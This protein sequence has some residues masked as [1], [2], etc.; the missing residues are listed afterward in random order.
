M[1][2]IRP[3]LPTH[4]AASTALRSYLADVA[5]R[6]YGRPATADEVDAALRD[7]PSDE[8]APPT[9]A[10]WLAELDGRVVGCIGV[11]RVR[12]EQVRV[13]HVPDEGAAM[14]T[15]GGKT[16]L[17]GEVKRVWVDASARGR[18]VGAALL[19]TVEQHAREHGLTTLRLDTRDDLV[20]SHR[21]YERHG[22]VR[23]PAFNAGPYAQRWYAKELDPAGT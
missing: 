15:A 18:G 4:P 8:L 12:V 2:C 11:E 5:G 13:G 17:V 3:A 23:V 7:D 21:L 6:W 14:G 16:A 20:E 19:T 9:G 22:F 10:F 1:I